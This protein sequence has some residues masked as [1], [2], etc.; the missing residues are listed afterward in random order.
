MHKNELFKILTEEIYPFWNHL[1]D[2]NGGFFSLVDNDGNIHKEADRGVL[3][4]LRILWFYS[5]LYSVYPTKEVK[6]YAQ[7]AFDFVTKYFMTHQG[8]IWK[9][10]HQFYIVDD[11][12]HIYNQ[13]FTVYAL[14]QYYQSFKD[15]NALKK[16]LNIFEVMESMRDENGYIEQLT[17]GNRLADL[18]FHADRTMNSILHMIEAYTLLYEVSENKK[19]HQALI[20]A[21]ELI[22]NKIYNPTKN[23]LEVMFNHDMISLVD[24]HSFGHDIEASWLLRLTLPYIDNQNLKNKIIN[25]SDAL[26]SEVYQKAYKNGYVISEK[27]LGIASESKV[28]WC[29]AEAV[30]G[31][32]KAYEINHL[33]PYKTARDQIL[34][35]IHHHFIHHAHK[36]WYWELNIENEPNLERPL[37]SNWKC[38]Y[39]NGRMYIEL[40][41]GIK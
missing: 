5:K 25:I 3:L 32:H 33:T 21:L 9:I 20:Y 6:K 26:V 19:V 23:R 22:S 29:Q 16:A 8:T 4:Q 14:S 39:H 17:K 34:N 27:V 11:T 24:Y 41:K 37:V 18:G 15:D 31:F 13:A 12:I 38:P 35:F 30:V 10:D 2:P 1:Y 28:W 40:V 36:E 7:H